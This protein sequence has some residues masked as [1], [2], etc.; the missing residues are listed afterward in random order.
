MSNLCVN[1]GEEVG[2]NVFTV[3]EKCWGKKYEINGGKT[4]APPETPFSIFQQEP[5][6]SSEPFD[7]F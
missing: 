1:C 2:N 3:C 4:I 5:Y 7:N 6:N